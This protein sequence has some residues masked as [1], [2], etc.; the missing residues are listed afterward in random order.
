MHMSSKPGWCT[1]TLFV[2]EACTK[3]PQ[4]VVGVQQVDRVGRFAS[5]SRRYICQKP[6]KSH[7]VGSRAMEGCEQRQPGL[8]LRGLI[9]RAILPVE[10]P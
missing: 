4:M 7:D 6:K 10:A 3:D 8:W 9:P 5:M 2:I 1:A